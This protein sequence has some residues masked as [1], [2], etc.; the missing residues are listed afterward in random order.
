MKLNLAKQSFPFVCSS[1]R[2]APTAWFYENG[3]DHGHWGWGWGNTMFLKYQEKY[4]PM[5]K[6]FSFSSNPWR[7]CLDH[8]IFVELT[9]VHSL[10]GSH[11]LD[12]LH[13]LRSTNPLSWPVF[14]ESFL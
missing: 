12:S 5:P 4:N 11:G 7:A 13:I 6:E 8:S 10:L 14:I 1:F 9:L 3:D 2:A